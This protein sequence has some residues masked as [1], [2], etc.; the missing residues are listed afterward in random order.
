MPVVGGRRVSQET[1]DKVKESGYYNPKTGKTLPPNKKSSSK[2]N[3]GGSSRK[4][5]S[6]KDTVAVTRPREGGGTITISKGGLVTERDLS[7]RKIKTLNL[8]DEATKKIL[9]SGSKLDSTSMISNG[10]VITISKP[11]A[12][13]VAQLQKK[14][15]AS[16]RDSFARARLRGD[17]V[18]NRAGMLEAK[19]KTGQEALS[20]ALAVDRR[21]V[22]Q[23]Q[24]QAQQEVNIIATKKQEVKTN[25]EKALA[26]LFK[27]QE[28]GVSKYDFKKERFRQALNKAT[29][30]EQKSQERIDKISNTFGQGVDKVFGRGAQNTFAG[31]FFVS[32]ATGVN[33]LVLGESLA[34]AADKSQLAI[35]GYLA[36]E[37]ESVT[38]EL[39]QAGQNVKPYFDIKTREG[40]ITYASAALG[41]AFPAVTR[42]STNKG[43]V[44]EGTKAQ[45]KRVTNN[46]NAFIEVTDITTQAKVG[47]KTYEVKGGSVIQGRPS[48]IDNDIIGFQ[49]KQ[50]IKTDTGLTAGS[51]ILGVTKIKDGLSESVIGVKTKTDKGFMSE[52][53]SAVKTQS[54][55]DLQGLQT[56]RSIITDFEVFGDTFKPSRVGVSGSQEI[57]KVSANDLTFTQLKSAEAATS[58]NLKMY[59]DLLNIQESGKGVLNQ[60]S[61]RTTTK[62]VIDTPQV[63]LG[64]LQLESTIKNV[65]FKDVAPKSSQI[66]VVS[67]I[68]NTSPVV[69]NIRPSTTKKVKT[70]QK[71][72]TVDAVSSDLEQGS[73]NKIVN[74]MVSKQD[75][76]AFQDVINDVKP[77][78]DVKTN[79]NQ[80]PITDVV[81]DISLIQD[82]QQVQKPITDVVQEV[83]TINKPLIN[84]FRNIEPNK[85]LKPFTGF[86]DLDN[87]KGVVP[88][89][90]VFVRGKGVFKPVQGGLTKGEAVSLGA[91]IARTSSV[92]SFKV[93]KMGKPVNVSVFDSLLKGQFRLSKSDRGVLVEKSKYRIDTEGELRDITYKGLAALKFKSGLL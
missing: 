84:T 26:E 30:R 35:K 5:S 74:R 67:P 29:K 68:T 40:K 70:E 25:N 59:K 31:E 15:V 52:T 33:P 11:S 45:T 13:R 87:N 20:L 76:N 14:E 91:D 57:V 8:S 88:S 63:S 7:G 2:K 72:V 93:L 92:A 79:Q 16:A 50:A 66:L 28:L 83:V 47:S 4:V 82:Q 69:S 78:Q 1:Y 41:A 38:K 53:A 42:V 43:V 37:G 56:S 75:V 6:S 80:K 62:T 85:P 24:K 86:I 34:G 46:E 73:V 71:I 65:V 90:Q 64:Q 23:A 89:F 18:I 60:G 19:T 54:V 81:Q 27:P 77:I 48:L 3:G 58:G 17:I 39:T 36:G 12:E 55:K 22:E 44:L 10:K 51:D 32:F 9:S 21:S 49:G 61:A